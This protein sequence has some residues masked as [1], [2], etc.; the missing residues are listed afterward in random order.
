[1][2]EI[3]RL[4]VAA[5][6]GEPQAAADL[7][8]LVYDELRK[9]AAARLA[10]EKPGQTL[11]ATALVHEVYLRLVNSDPAKPWAGRAHFFAA[12]AEA[13][14]RILIEHAR[15]KR[16][17]RRGGDRHRITLTVD[18]SGQTDPDIDVLD[19]D[20]AIMQFSKGNPESAEL[21]KLRFF[22]GMTV[23]EA[24]AVLQISVT[25]AERQWRYARA[26]LADFISGAHHVSKK[27]EGPSD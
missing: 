27:I 15:R 10:S 1:M 7:L 20:E 23:P 5:A 6:A 18:L 26:W 25:S 9:L 22:V 14:R 21:I 12:A 13:M 24:A 8:P 3:T 2:S 17:L 4:I 11:Q 19:L 16:R